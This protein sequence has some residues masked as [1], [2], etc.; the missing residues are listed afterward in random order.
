MWWFF[1]VWNKQKLDSKH[2]CHNKNRSWKLL[3]FAI[4]R[5][6]NLDHFSVF[7]C[8]F[9]WVRKAIWLA[10]TIY[11]MKSNTHTHNVGIHSISHYLT[12][13]NH[14]FGAIYYHLIF[15]KE[16]HFYSIPSSMKN[17]HFSCLEK[18]S[19]FLHRFLILYST[20]PARRKGPV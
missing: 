2:I 3:H 13:C 16:N 6:I 15:Y 11:T 8:H 5:S 18:S 10:Y 17:N 12:H 9:N 20:Y 1:F 7:I 19:I 4:N 14:F